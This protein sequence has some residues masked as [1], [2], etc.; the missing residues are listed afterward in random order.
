M[1]FSSSARI[2]QPLAEGQRCHLDAK[3]FILTGPSCQR[4]EQGS[5]AVRGV[6]AAGDV[7]SRSVK[8][9]GA[10]ISEGAVVATELHCHSPECQRNSALGLGLAGSAL[11]RPRA[12]WSRERFHSGEPS[13]EIREPGARRRIPWRELPIHQVSTSAPT[14]GAM[15]SKIP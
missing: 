7:R 3:N 2:R 4:P 11:L 13:T 10:A 1:S 9:V 5:S 15:T 8:R 6:L 14:K 12:A